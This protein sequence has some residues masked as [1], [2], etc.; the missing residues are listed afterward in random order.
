MARPRR[1]LPSNEPVERPAELAASVPF[2]PMEAELV[3][4]LPSEDGWQFEPKWDGFRGLLENTGDELRLWSRNARPLLRYFPELRPLA[5]LLPPESALDGEIVI[6]RDGVLDFDAMQTR[7][8]PA[9]SR[10]NRLSA[11]IPAQFVAF[12]VLVWKG[13]EIWRKSLSERRRE[14]ER[15]A[16]RFSLSPA[17]QDRGEA[18][19]WLDRF[20]AIGLDGVVAKRLDLPYLPG[21]RERR[22][23]GEAREDRRLRRRRAC[24]GRS[25]PDRVATLLLGLYDDDGE[26]DYVGVGGRR[27]RKA[28]PDR[29][30]RPSAPRERSR[31]ALLG[32][33]PLG[34]RRAR[35]VPGPPG[36]RRRGALRQGAVEPLPP[37]DEA[38]PLPR[39]QGAAAVHLA[40]A[41][42]APK[43][44]RHGQRA[45]A[46]LDV[47]SQRPGCK[48]AGFRGLR[49][50]R[51]P[52]SRIPF[53]R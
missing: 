48:A 13:E 1:R 28:R 51:N 22:R 39:R 2:P 7:L 16:K 46:K 3:R 36:A 20:E 17:S 11:E 37:R 31:A 32:T 43:A 9:E 33:E 24:A 14:L 44:W 15:K 27:A 35:G 26:I 47:S 42:P 6:S 25:R 52:R 38:H 21:S 5:K 30:T 10:I 34:R 18:L 8:H 50:E 49:A 23:Q 29:G 53:S 40:R 45:S 4:D 19:G 12:D 41:A